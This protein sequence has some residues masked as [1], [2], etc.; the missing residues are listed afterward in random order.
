MN[1]KVLSIILISVLLLGMMMW[2]FYE[3]LN[4]YSRNPSNMWSKDLEVGEKT[5]NASSPLFYNEGKVY[6]L[7]A[8]EEGFSLRE[9]Y[10]DL[11]EEQKIIVRDFKESSIRRIRY[12]DGKIFWIQDGKVKDL[13]LGQ[14]KEVDLGLKGEDFALT[15]NHLLLSDE[16]GIKIFDFSMSSISFLPFFNVSK[17]DAFE[18]GDVIYV[19]FLTDDREENKIY[20]TYY[21]LKKGEWSKAVEI[22]KLFQTSTS[23]IDDVKIALDSSGVY[24]FYLITAKNGSSAYYAYFPMT[25]EKE[26]APSKITLPSSEII[27]FDLISLPEGVVGAFSAPVKY[28]VFGP[29]SQSGVE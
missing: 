14:E 15:Q 12:K 19:G 20:Y 7:W 5:L 11:K 25:G 1:K 22:Y 24:V 26:I 4:A 27:S 18:E 29:F 28:Q 3:Y 16:K 13:I 10:P 6:I 21:D 2:H 8:K 17:I 9:V 23:H